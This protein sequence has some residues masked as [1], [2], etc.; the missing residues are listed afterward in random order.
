MSG[1]IREPLRKKPRLDV[2]SSQVEMYG[3]LS[4]PESY[5]DW[6]F[7]DSER[8]SFCDE[9]SSDSEV[10]EFFREFSETKVP[11]TSGDSFARPSTFTTGKVPLPAPHPVS[12]PTNPS[13]QLPN[14]NP[15]ARKVIGRPT[16]A[17]QP[18]QFPQQQPAKVSSFS[19][20]SIPF[21]GN[22]VVPNPSPMMPL[23]SLPPQM[24]LWNPAL[25]TVMHP[26]FQSVPVQQNVQVPNR[27]VKRPRSPTS[28]ISPNSSGVKSPEAPMTP[29]GTTGA[30]PADVKL[31]KAG[32]KVISRG[33]E[34]KKIK[35]P[36]L[37]R[38]RPIQ[39]PMQT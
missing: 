8:N 7:L 21:P 6:D 20:V 36:F 39:I 22:V 14:S 3:S 15:G 24:L 38:N 19:H 29:P 34:A 35:A 1:K 13:K 4:S 18:K 28:P 32:P 12:R 23:Q 2:D 25:A 26:H 16:G 9:D 30:M 31:I 37:K 27:G 17:Q 33:A 5:T 11:Q 10:E